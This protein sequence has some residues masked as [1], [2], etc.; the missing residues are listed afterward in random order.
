MVPKLIALLSM[1]TDNEI[2]NTIKYIFSNPD[3]AKKKSLKLYSYI[4]EEYNLD[5]VCKLLYNIYINIQH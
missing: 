5:I 3:L 1:Q 4:K 2:I